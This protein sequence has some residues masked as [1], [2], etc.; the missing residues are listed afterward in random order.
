MIDATQYQQL[1]RAVFANASV[2]AG[3]L[4]PMIQYT[5][6]GVLAIAGESV[7]RI[8]FGIASEISPTAAL[9]EIL[10]ET[11]KLMDFGHYWLAAG[12]DNENWSLVCGFKIPYATATAEHVVELAS[13]IANGGSDAIA[14]VVR[15]KI[16]STPH[17]PY[18]LDDTDPGA[19]ALV[20][21]PR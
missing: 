10:D 20:A 12:A 6:S 11:N 4:T 16:A 13:G 21:G 3:E 15:Q 7:G 19:Q 8:G 1:T 5:S 18:W 14:N 2:G 9:L 17:R